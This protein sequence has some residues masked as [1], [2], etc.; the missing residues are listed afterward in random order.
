MPEKLLEDPVLKYVEDDPW[1]NMAMIANWRRKQLFGLE[2]K[3]VIDIAE[4]DW[5]K[6]KMIGTQAYTVNAYMIPTKNA[7]YFPMAYLQPPF[8]DLEQRGIEYNLAYIGYTVGH[9]ISH[10]LD[11]Q[12]S[13]F[14]ADGNMISWWSDTDRERFKKKGEDVI[15]QYEEFAA[16]DGII[17]DAKLG[18]G[19]DLA[20]ISGL[21][22]SE[23]YL[24][25]FL[26]ANKNQSLI[27]KLSLARFYT[28]CAVNQ[29]KKSMV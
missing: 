14:D 21:S 27:K 6:F 11:N 15:K 1:V 8:I 7:I 5:D 9:E 29:D 22:L 26:L 4:I 25:Y 20:D 17:F 28:Y 3:N 23:E 18:L 10:C 2:G 19:E 12:G 13:K 16:R 24:F